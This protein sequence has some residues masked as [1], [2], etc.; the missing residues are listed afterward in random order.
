[1]FECPA[2]R[3]ATFPLTS[4]CHLMQSDHGVRRLLVTGK[5]HKTFTRLNSLSLLAW[6]NQS[7]DNQYDVGHPGFGLNTNGQSISE[8][9]FHGSMFSKGPTSNFC[10][11]NFYFFPRTSEK[12][13]KTQTRLREAGGAVN[14]WKQSLQM[15]YFFSQAKLYTKNVLN[16]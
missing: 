2:A 12:D 15:M 4:F 10:R 11:R 7:E 16:W 5:K 13:P 14:I 8:K 9:R 3:Q 1:M 6:S